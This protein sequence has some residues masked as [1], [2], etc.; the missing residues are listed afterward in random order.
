ML[1]N[2]VAVVVAAVT[3]VVAMEE[4]IVVAVVVAVVAAVVVAAATVVV[5]GE[6]SGCPVRTYSTV[7]CHPPLPPPP[8]P[9]PPPCPPTVNAMDDDE[10]DEDDATKASPSSS[11]ATVWKGRAPS[12][13]ATLP[14]R[15]TI[16][17][18]ISSPCTRANACRKSDRVRSKGRM[19]L[20]RVCSAD[21]DARGPR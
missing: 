7:E 15:K 2:V 14:R 18:S 21:G 10:E 13:E 5:S 1:D 6:N 16:F 17:S 12:I 20:A 3:V 8:P 19:S 9:P 4:V 11:V